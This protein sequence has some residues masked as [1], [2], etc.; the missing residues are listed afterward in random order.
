MGLQTSGTPMIT[1]LALLACTGGDAPS[2]T[3][4][5]PRAVNAPLPAVAPAVGQDPN[6]TVA[7]WQGGELDYKAVQ[8]KISNELIRLE[9]EY[10]QN[11]YNAEKSAMEE[12]AYEALIKAEATK[13]GISEEALIKAEVEDKVAKPTDAEVE[14]FYNMVKRQVRNQPLEQVRP[15]VE[16]GLVMRR[17]AERMQAWLDELKASYELQFSLPYPDLPRLQV[18]VDDDPALGKTD[19]PI[20]I[21][22]FADFQCGYCRKIYPTLRE[23][24]EEY[25]D[26]IQLVYR[27]YPLGGPNPAGMSPSIAANCAGVQGKYWEMHDLLMKS[28]GFAAPQLEAHATAAG[29]DLNQWKDCVASSSAQVEEITA[30]FEAGRELGVSGT[31]A[32]FVNGIFLNGAV[33]KEQFE[34]LIER[35]LAGS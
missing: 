26:K 8:A 20:T 3:A 14:E 12:A 31:P 5:A 2:T 27:D 1:L 15:Q 16:E 4:N 23:L 9:V 18:S 24:L 33:P 25:P 19:A 11:R 32:F 22:E 28:G 34:T 13:R 35:E 6:G 10:L 7:S 17:Q 30:D 29:V 21:V